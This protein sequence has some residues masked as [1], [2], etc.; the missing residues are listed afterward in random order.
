MIEIT[1][2]G[3]ARTVPPDLTLPQLLSVLG[4]ENQPLI[5]EHNH[6]AL[7]KNEWSSIRI[8][9]ADEIEFIRVVAGG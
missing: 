5:I 3:I 6:T 1:V 8:A 2:N 7:L 9:E 4:L